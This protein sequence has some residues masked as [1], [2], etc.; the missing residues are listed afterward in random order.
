MTS[1]IESFIPSKHTPFYENE[2]NERE[3]MQWRQLIYNKTSKSKD[4]KIIKE[5]NALC[6]IVGI[7]KA[8]IRYAVLIITKK[9]L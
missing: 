5:N 7:I 8:L 9:V 2:Q 3:I 1:L 4:F 6:T